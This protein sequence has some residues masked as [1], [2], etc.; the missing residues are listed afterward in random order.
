[1]HQNGENKDLV[2][3]HRLGRRIAVPYT[4]CEAVSWIAYI[5]RWIYTFGGH[6]VVRDLKTVCDQDGEQGQLKYQTNQI[7]NKKHRYVLIRS[8]DNNS[9][10]L[11]NN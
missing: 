2:R 4:E 8:F 3:I 11:Y 7:T 5:S 9:I 10:D 1:M 6:G